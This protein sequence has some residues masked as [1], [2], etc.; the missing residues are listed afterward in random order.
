MVT[1]F[2]HITNEL[3]AFERE[4]IVP[5]IVKSWKRRD[6]SSKQIITMKEMIKKTNDFCKKENI[7]SYR[8]LKKGSIKTSTKC[9]IINGPR[10][11][12]VIHYIRVKGLIIDLIATSNGYFRS[13]DANEIANFIKSCRQ[14]ANS[15]NEVARAME[16]YNFER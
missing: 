3:T 15:F 1:G 4:K 13:N 11:R 8:V 16:V 6:P 14:R 5:I 10:M 9:Y 7:R 12:K 2:E